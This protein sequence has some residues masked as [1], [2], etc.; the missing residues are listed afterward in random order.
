M[1]VKVFTPFLFSLSFSLCYSIYFQLFSTNFLTLFYSIFTNHT[2]NKTENK[3]NGF[4][5]VVY[6]ARF[7]LCFIPTRLRTLQIEKY[8]LFFSV[9]KQYL[10]NILGLLFF[11]Q[12]ASLSC[13]FDTLIRQLILLKEIW[14]VIKKKEGN[15]IV[16]KKTIINQIHMTT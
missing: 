8:Y 10:F 2:L 16:Y 9:N 12:Q 5:N 15:L 4:L 11:C 1:R 14:F 13:W 6:Y 3:Y 7:Q